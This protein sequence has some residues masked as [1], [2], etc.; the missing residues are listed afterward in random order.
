MTP[1]TTAVALKVSEAENEKLLWRGPRMQT[2][3]AT[4]FD[5]H[6]ANVEIV[7]VFALR[8]GECPGLLGAALEDIT[9]DSPGNKTQALDATSREMRW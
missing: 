4:A 7:A 3:R 9:L 2:L 5:D 6:L 8:I 1:M